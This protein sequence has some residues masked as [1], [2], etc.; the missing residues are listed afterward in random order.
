MA[1]VVGTA[2]ACVVGITVTCVVGVVGAGSVLVGM[3]DGCG[4]LVGAW[5]VGV[6]STIPGVRVGAGV[7]VSFLQPTTANTRSVKTSST[8]LRRAAEA[9]CPLLVRFIQPVPPVW[10]SDSGW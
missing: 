6:T 3:G 2:V 1:S 4:A 7:G 9:A 8:P 10:M 5:M